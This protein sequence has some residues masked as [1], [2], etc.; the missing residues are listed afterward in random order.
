MGYTFHYYWCFCTSN[1]FE[2]CPSP[3]N[4]IKSS[5]V[6][7]KKPWLPLISPPVLL[8][9]QIKILLITLKYK[10]SAINGYKI[11]LCLTSSGHTF[12][13]PKKGT[14]T[15]LKNIQNPSQGF[16]IFFSIACKSVNGIHK[17]FELPT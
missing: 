17:L 8:I 10:M 13:Y 15:I 7:S 12:Y 11:Q 6:L 3:L 16:W 2:E 14:I 9:R 5:L 1:N 4:T